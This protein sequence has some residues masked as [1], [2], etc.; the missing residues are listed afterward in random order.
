MS[1]DIKFWRYYIPSV[2]GVEGWGIITLDSTGVFSAV[3]DYGNAAYKFE[4]RDGED[5]REYFAKGVPGN[6]M[7]K[8]FYNL[9]CYDADETLRRVKEDILYQRLEHSLT[10]AR[11]REEWDLLFQN[12]W[13]D[14]DAN[15]VRWYDETRITDAGEHY[16]L[17]YPASCRA[18]VNKLM[19][20]F[21]EAVAVELANELITTP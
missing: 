14:N 19:P 17:G 3:T 11:A 10:R 5:I 15:F 20:R 1:K 16:T 4:V 18:F 6:L 12:D 21:C 13:L 2:D 8:L 7:E 9:R